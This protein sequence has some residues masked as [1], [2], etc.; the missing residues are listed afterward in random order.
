VAIKFLQQGID[1]DA[2]IERFRTERQI[3]NSTRTRPARC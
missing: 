1:D 2:G 3:L